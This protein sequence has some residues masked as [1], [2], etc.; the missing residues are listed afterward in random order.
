MAGEDFASRTQAAVQS[1]AERGAQIA[2]GILLLWFAGLC[3]FIAFMSG[4]TPGL[5]VGKDKSGKP[6]GPKDVTEL[7]G[8]LSENIHAAGGK[9]VAHEGS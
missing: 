5:T 7:M 1:G 2:V 4:K 6:Q 8:R 9:P 3:L